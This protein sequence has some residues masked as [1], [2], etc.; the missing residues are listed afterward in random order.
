VSG[1]GG[2]YLQQFK[3]TLA[4]FAQ[5]RAAIFIWMIG[6]IL[7]P[8]V[9]LVVWSAVAAARGRDVGGYGPGEFAAYFLVLMLVN[10]ATYTWIMY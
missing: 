9:F 2:I 5:Y 10:H 3:T 6:H 8:L 1:L 4:S 7:E